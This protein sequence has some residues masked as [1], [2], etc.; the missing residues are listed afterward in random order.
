MSDSDW[1]VQHSTTGFIFTYAQAAISWGCKK[2]A[3]IA[4]SSCEAEIVALSEASKEAVFLS[5]YLTELGYPSQS[6]TSL[7]TDNEGA[8]ALSYNPEHHEKVKHVERRHFYIRELVEEQLLVVP[9]VNTHDNLADFLTKPLPGNS[10]YKL[11]NQIMNVDRSASR[12]D[13]SVAASGSSHGGVSKGSPT[14][15]PPS[16]SVPTLVPPGPK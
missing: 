13:P 11:R 2:Q 3:T 6:P 16:T 15:V 1:A 9:Y 4:L 5:R 7:A 14:L 10:F 8:R 12:P